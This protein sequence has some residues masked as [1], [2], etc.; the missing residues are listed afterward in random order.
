MQEKNVREEYLIIMHREPYNDEKIKMK[1]VKWK[2]EKSQRRTS[3]YVPS[4]GSR[5]SYQYR[6]QEI[7]ALLHYHIN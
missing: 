4:W 5:G 7:T 1:C 3:D 2:F 6:F